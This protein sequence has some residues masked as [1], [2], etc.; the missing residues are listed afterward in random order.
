MKGNLLFLCT[1]HFDLYKIFQHGFEHY[2]GLGKKVIT[3]N[4]DIVNYDFFS[5]SNIFIWNESTLA[6][7]DEFFTSHYQEPSDTIYKKYSREYWVKTVL[8]LPGRAEHSCGP[9]TRTVAGQRSEPA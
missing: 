9:I 5:P 1:S 3:T 8:G 6:I 4:A 2:S 7:P